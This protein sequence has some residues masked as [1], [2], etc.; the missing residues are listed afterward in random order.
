[1]RVESLRSTERAVVPFSKRRRVLTVRFPARTT[2]WFSRLALSVATEV[3]RL[4]ELD[5]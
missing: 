1:M 4:A 3:A 2:L 5:V